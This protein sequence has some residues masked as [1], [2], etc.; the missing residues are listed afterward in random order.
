M[1][2]HA[3]A[4]R[5]G[6]YTGWIQT[7]AS[8]GLIGA[9]GV[10]YAARTL[11][12]TDA[13]NAWGWRIP[14]FFSALLLLISIFMRARLGESPSFKKMEAEGSSSRAPFAEAFGTWRYAKVVIVALLAIMVAQGVVWYA[15]FFYVQTFMAQ[16][17]KVEANTVTLLVLAATVISAPLYVFFAWLSDRIGRKPVMLFGMVLTILA[18]FPGFHLLTLYANPALAAAAW[19]A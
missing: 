7:S 14:F 2:E 8:F 15:I 6:E 11:L 10:I 17:L 19:L 1:A 13:F 9:L 18:A 12:G 4:G 16:I 3:P 5:R